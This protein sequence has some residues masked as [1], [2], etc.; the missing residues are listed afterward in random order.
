ME[1]L[2]DGFVAL[3][4]GSGT[5]DELMEVVTWAQ[6]GLHRKPIGL[7]DVDGYFEHL[8]GLPRPRGGRALRA[9]RAPRAAAARHRRRGPAGADGGLGARGR[10]DVDRP[11]GVLRWD[12]AAASAAVGGVGPG[13]DVPP[14]PPPPP[15]SGGAGG[16]PPPGRARTRRARLDEAPRPPWYPVPLSELCILAGLV[17]LGFGALGSGGRRGVLLA[18][19]F[20]LVGLASLEVALREHLA[21][22]RSHSALLAFAGALAVIVPIALLT[23]MPRPAGRR[24]GRRAVRRRVPRAARALPAAVGRLRVPCLGALGCLVDERPAPDAPARPAPRDGDLRRP[25]SHDRLLPRP[26]RA[27][28]RARGRQRRRPLRAALLVRRR[29]GQPGDARVVP[30][31]PGDGGRP[32]RPRR[33]PS[34]RASPSPPTRSSSPGGTTCARATCPA[35]TSSTAAVCARCTSATLTATSSRWRSAGRRSGGRPT[36]LPVRA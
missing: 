3:P 4:G 16:G 32:G 9:P 29:R 36:A 33:D 28:A 24:A 15:P 10:A 7:L 25:R 18:L 11:G 8:D 2:A 13:A 17:C 14:P 21:G 20:A 6:L 1:E 5:L 23:G 22:Y 19:G 34:L 27:R 26:A 12:A 35:P 30:G 31:V